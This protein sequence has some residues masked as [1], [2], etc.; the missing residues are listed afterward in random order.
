MI[1]EEIRKMAKL[2][3]DLEAIEEA[4][5]RVDVSRKVTFTYISNGAQQAITFVEDC[6]PSCSGGGCKL[7]STDI[8]A[9]V[10]TAAKKVAV[11]A[12]GAKRAEILEKLKALGYEEPDGQHEYGDEA[13]CTV[14]E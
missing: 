7:T 6:P 8:A 13:G 1:K 12:I 4:A 14:A 11:D 10:L 9:D 2:L 5:R 3:D